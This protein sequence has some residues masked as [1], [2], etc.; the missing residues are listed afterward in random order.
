MTRTAANGSAL[1]SLLAT[2]RVFGQAD[3]RLGEPTARPERPGMSYSMIG[4]VGGIRDRAEVLQ[5]P[6][7]GAWNSTASPPE[8]RR[9]RPLRRTRQFDGGGCRWCRRRRPPWPGRPRRP[10]PR[11]AGPLS[12]SLVVG[13]SPVVPLMTRPSLPRSTRSGGQLGGGPQ[14][15]FSVIGERRHHCREDSS[16]RCI[17]HRFTGPQSADRSTYVRATL[18]CSAW[19]R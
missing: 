3:E 7:W 14:I 6:A 5:E 10:A 4:K 12:A 11:A 2:M 17:C 1:A 9:R 18:S 15:Q 19:R 16:E 8:G 13:D